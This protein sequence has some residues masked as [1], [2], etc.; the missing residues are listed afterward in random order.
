[1]E[2]DIQNL[3]N[4]GSPLDIIKYL[5]DI[6]I[7]DRTRLCPSCD[8]PMKF[9][10]I[11]K[12]V[13]KC[14]FM[15]QNK[16]CSKRRSIHSPRTNS[17][18]ENYR[19]PIHQLLKIYNLWS[20]NMQVKQVV[21]LTGVGRC[22]VI[23]VYDSIRL[24][25]SKDQNE[26]SAAG[27]SLGGPGTICQIDESQF[28]HRVKAHRGRAPSNPSWV[29]GI[30]DCSSKPAKTM[31]K[32]VPDR[33]ASS[34]IPIIEDNIKPGTTVRSDCWPSYNSLTTGTRPLPYIHQ[35]VN[36]ETNFVEEKY[37]ELT[38]KTVPVHTQSI[39][40]SWNKAKMKI[41]NMKG[42]RKTSLQGYLD[43]CSWRGQV[44]GETSTA[45]MER[46]LRSK[47]R[48]HQK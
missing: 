48:Y 29:F 7:I 46:V 3:I 23:K 42:C 20:L 28:G 9:L 21:E 24:A 31:M 4:S 43:E 40:S 1:M 45:R 12:K 27:P 19:L 36:H 38:G 10:E 35:T 33:S 34:L 15:C 26:L 17:I 47:K 41:K 18:F 13:D 5:Q 22:T 14:G 25:C 11:Q 37:D 30:A 32:V 6:D 16:A 39:E 2:K 44:A 8:L